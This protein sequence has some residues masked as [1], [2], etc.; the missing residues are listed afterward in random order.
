MVGLC[1]KAASEAMIEHGA[2]VK[3]IGFGNF[4]TALNSMKTIAT[5]DMI[6]MYEKFQSSNQFPQTQTQ[7]KTVTVTEI[8]IEIDLSSQETCPPDDLR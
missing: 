8:E 6:D 1:H 5:K 7:T 2:S 3:E 4:L